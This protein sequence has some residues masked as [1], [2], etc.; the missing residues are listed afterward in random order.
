MTVFEKVRRLRQVE[1]PWW[2]A[3]VGCTS[4]VVLGHFLRQLNI[5]LN[6]LAWSSAE[7]ISALLS[8][9][10]AASVLVRYHGTGNRVTLLLG[11]TFGVTGMIHLGAIFEFY[12]RFLK[13]SQHVRVPVSWMVGQMLLGILL[14]VACV[15][16][17]WLPWPRDPGK[18]VIALSSIV[19]SATFLVTATF[20]IFPIAPVIDPHSPTP[21]VW[22]LL[23][24][25]IFLVAA[26]SLSSV[27][28]S[29]G[30]AFDTALVWVAGLNVVSHLIASQSARL[31]DAAAGVAELVNAISYIVLLGATL[32]DNARLFRRVRTLAIS[33]S[34]TG[35]ANYRHLVDILQSELERSGRTNRSFSLLLMDLDGLK[36]I[37]D[38]YGHVI[39]SRALCRVATILKLNCRS[40]DTAARYGGDEFALVLPET[41]HFAAEQVVERVRN[42][43]LAD[44]EHPPL[45]MSIGVATFP[46]CGVTVQQLLEFADK[47][48]YAMKEQSKG[49]TEK[50][51]RS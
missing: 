51:K 42:C 26:V 46:K 37:N 19:I 35:L 29:D 8:F 15:I 43:L 4:G 33:D 7:I 30:F 39:G 11:L 24:A 14:L 21:R 36:K 48:L 9:M 38:Q 17:R 1:R 28:E 34:L 6:P 50:R 41:N 25:L 16:N 13:P 47:S 31:L 10:I 27:R 23:P 5:V 49:R 20:L 22:E 44:E 2:L 12:D 18:N 3:L 45:S 40:I 32:L